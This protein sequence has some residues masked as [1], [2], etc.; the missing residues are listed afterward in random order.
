MLSTRYTITEDQLLIAKLYNTST[1]P[2]IKKR[3]LLSWLMIPVL[4]GVLGYIFWANGSEKMV[5]FFFAFSFLWILLYPFW[6]GNRFKKSYKNGL[7]RSSKDILDKDNVITFGDQ[8]TIVSGEQTEN[9]TYQE[10]N[11]LVAIKNYVLFLFPKERT[12][13][14]P[15]EKMPD[16]IL[17]FLQKEKSIPLTVRPGWKWR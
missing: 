8:I 12:I 15:H 1:N 11:Q 3:R 7:K 2:S 5:Y 9:Y 16:E 10:L 17:Q 4:Y 14:V 6:E 13:A